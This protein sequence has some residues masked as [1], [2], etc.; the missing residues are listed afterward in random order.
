VS[1][2]SLITLPQP[3]T[4]ALGGVRDTLP[5]KN[6]LE[7]PVAFSHILSNCIQV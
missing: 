4:E 2:A 1:S 5:S 6:E 3:M 7:H